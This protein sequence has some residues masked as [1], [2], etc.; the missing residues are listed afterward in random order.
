M[1]N[2]PSTRIIDSI[3]DAILRKQYGFSVP[4]SRDGKINCV[5]QMFN[6]D[7]TGLVV[8]LSDFAVKV[9]NV[10]AYV[11]TKNNN[12]DKI[13]KKYFEIVNND[14]AHLGVR[15]GIAGLREQFMREYFQGS[16]FPVLVYDGTMNI[17][18]YTL[19]SNLYF[20]DGSSLKCK[21]SNNGFTKYQY[22]FA[23]DTNIPTNSIITKPFAR[24]QDDFPSPFLIRRGV[25]PSW[26]IINDLKHKQN[27]ILNK[28]LP[29]L[30]T[31]SRGND[32]MTKNGVEITANDFEKIENDINELIE[33]KDSATVPTRISG[34]DEKILQ[35]IPDIENMFKDKLITAAE[36]SILCSFGFVDLA[37]GVSTSR[38]ESVLNPKAFI[39][40]IEES[41][42]IFNDC[43][44]KP[45]IYKIAEMNKSEHPKMFIKG[46]DIVSN[47][48]KTFTSEEAFRMI[49]SCYDRG[50]ISKRTLTD[51]VAD[52]D[53]DFERYN[54]IQE[55][56]NGDDVLMY[57]QII[58]NQEANVSPIEQ[59]RDGLVNQK[60]P[61][62]EYVEKEI[63]GDLE[64]MSND[65]TD[66][67][68][69]DF[70]NAMLDIKET[71]ID[72]DSDFYQDLL[73]D[74]SKE[75]FD[76]SYNK[77]IEVLKDKFDKDLAETLANK[78]AWR[79]VKAMTEKTKNGLVIKE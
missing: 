54:R 6:S 53:Y 29:F 64:N 23:D 9:G 14:W 60:S 19:P 75:L 46:F 26:S 4:S 36:K 15:M 11:S 10:P 1:N 30:L 39:S 49:R 34:Y 67:D 66:G 51:L 5:N 77:A 55:I 25:Y 12:I 31:V 74:E 72:K 65:K 22:T 79:Q 44:L 50:T 7:P 20:L 76:E 24:W 43:I 58:T 45:L 8:S 41:I 38:R 27:N 56:L 13:F 33:N 32:E 62:S 69:L 68:A 17:N 35:Q 37:D 78:Y 73:D 3:V 47:K 71:N 57:P 61:D 63:N 40:L 70:V 28:I 52:V 2:I 42:D 48:P 18:G 16:T 59:I 21:I